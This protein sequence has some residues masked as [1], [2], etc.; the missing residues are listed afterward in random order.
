MHNIPSQESGTT[1][2]AK[3]E[4]GVVAGAFAAHQRS[5]SSMMRVLGASLRASG[6]HVLTPSRAEPNMTHDSGVI[7]A[8]LPECGPRKQD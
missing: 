8:A 5:L 4:A 6:G 2:L 7:L 3:S 1:A